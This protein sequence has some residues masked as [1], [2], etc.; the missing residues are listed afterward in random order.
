MIWKL[1]ERIGIRSCH[2]YFGRSVP[3]SIE[4]PEI[5]YST[6]SSAAVVLPLEIFLESDRVARFSKKDQNKARELN[7][8]LLEK[9]HNKALANVQKYQESQEALLQQGCCST[10]A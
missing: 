2:Q 4:Q 7:F 3:T 5:L 10:R 8:N 9:K 6:W 1:K